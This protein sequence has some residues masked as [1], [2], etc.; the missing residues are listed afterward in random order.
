[1]LSNV[2]NDQDLEILRDSPR[3][4]DLVIR[5][6]EKDKES[7]D[8]SGLIPGSWETHGRTIDILII[9]Y[10]DGT[11]ELHEYYDFGFNGEGTW[12]FNTGSYN[13]LNA[14]FTLRLESGRDGSVSCYES[15]LS[16]ELDPENMSMLIYS[17]DEIKAPDY[18]D[19]AGS[20]G[21]VYLEKQYYH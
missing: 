8:Y 13:F 5:Y 14:D 6:R 15:N 17:F 4:Q 12:S 7:P 3:Y 9:F 18:D 1:M 10:E 20:D 19:P 11:A 16:A 2:I 21:P